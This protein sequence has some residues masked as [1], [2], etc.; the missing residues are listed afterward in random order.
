MLLLRYL[1]MQYDYS[2][3]VTHYIQHRLNLYRY[4][5]KHASLLNLFKYCFLIMI[6]FTISISVEMNK[7]S[8]KVGNILIIYACSVSLSHIWHN[9]YVN[10]TSMVTFY[11]GM[12]LICFHF[13]YF[14]CT[15]FQ[16]SSK[17]Q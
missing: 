11:V 3:F 13:Q 5:C 8:Q 1:K 9:L 15:V 7:R 4:L 14:V 10:F 12:F 17:M 16:I 6:L 2:V